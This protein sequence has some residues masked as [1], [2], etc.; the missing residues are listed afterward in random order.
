MCLCLHSQSAGSSD[1]MLQL[2]VRC[3]NS[4]FEIAFRVCSLRHSISSGIRPYRTV[5]QAVSRRLP[6]AWARL[7]ARPKSCGI[8]GGQSGTAVCFLQILCFHSTLI[9]CINCSTIITNYRQVL[10]RVLLFPLPLIHSTNYSTIITIYRQVFSWYFYF[11]Y[12]LFIPPITPQASSS[13]GRFSPSTSVSPTIHS[14]H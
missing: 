11:R 4:G 14:F 7:R 1:L 10:S 3:G 6:T 8:C 2:I 5:A 12:N 9:H 13:I